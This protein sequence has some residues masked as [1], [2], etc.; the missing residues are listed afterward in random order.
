V[1][2]LIVVLIG[3][4]LFRSYDLTQATT[5]L[6]AMAG[7]GGPGH[8]EAITLDAQ[9]LIAFAC[10]PLV[11]LPFSAK[12]TAWLRTRLDPATRASLRLSLSGWK[13]VAA[14]MILAYALAQVARSTYN[15]FI[16]FRF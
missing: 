6:R 7:T 16:Y 15:P 13:L 5:Q 14:V 8:T 2:T 10:A 1:Y 3:W 11:A 12:F 9:H 4:V